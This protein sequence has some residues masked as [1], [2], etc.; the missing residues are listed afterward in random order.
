M[1]GLLIPT[2]DPCEQMR[3]NLIYA[4]AMCAVHYMRARHSIPELG[5]V[6][7]MAA[8]WKKYY[9]TEKGAGTTEQFKKSTAPV[10]ALT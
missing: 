2:K 8:Y 1:P 10:F 9:N 7:G 6:D 5:D 4:A 3:V